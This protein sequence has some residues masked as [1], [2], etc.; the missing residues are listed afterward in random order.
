M[1][2]LC[3][4][5]KPFVIALVGGPCGGKSTTISAISTA[6]PDAVIVP[7]AATVLLSGGYPSP[8][9]T[10]GHT[11][12]WQEHFQ[13]AVTSV[14]LSLEETFKMLAVKRGS[15]MIVCD[16]GIL[17]GA[18]YCGGMD[19]FC[20]KF[21]IVKEEAYSRYDSVIHLESL[22]ISKPQLFGK[23]GNPTRYENLGKAIELDLSILEI[24]KEH[25]RRFVICGERSGEEQAERVV[26]TIRQLL[27]EKG[28]L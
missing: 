23:G 15:N 18:A 19:I 22:A 1:N 7:E 24:W 16:R 26:E 6:F 3:T 20:R 4:P 28:I 27:Q 10:L 2:P 9:E 13:K 14:Q 8:G 12:E 5:N 17:D 21:G 11:P 25:P